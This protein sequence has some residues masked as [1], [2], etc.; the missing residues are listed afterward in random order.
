M[1]NMKIGIDIDDTICDTWDFL[2]PYLSE[3]FN[4]EIKKLK[5]AQ[6]PYYEACNCTY[7]EYC[8][9]AMKYYSVYALQYK[10]KKDVVKIL[11]QLR[12]EGNQIIFISARSDN[13]F[14]DPYKTSLTYLVKN[15][16]P[17]D[18]LIVNA[19]DKRKVCIEEKIDLFIDDSVDNCKSV[20]YESIPV[21][22][23][24]AS[25]NKDCSLF[26]RVFNWKE[27]YKEVERM[28]GNG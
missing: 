13:G 27:I 24:N 17:F 3:Y 19:K 15:N 22:L 2:I 8:G 1:I 9:F 21:L 7:L 10:L 14:K 4:I 23:F 26:K 12:Q 18:K 5:K 6:V 25:Y 11:K 20:N 16:V 28:K